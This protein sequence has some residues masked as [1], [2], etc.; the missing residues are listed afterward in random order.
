MQKRD[1][2]A[3]VVYIGVAVAVSA[4]VAYFITSPKPKPMFTIY[5][6]GDI[7]LGTNTTITVS[8]TN[9]LFITFVD[10]SDAGV[11]GIVPEGDTEV[12]WVHEGEEFLRLSVM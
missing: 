2:F 8:D 4:L 11:L 9:V 7:L 10:D 3:V 1:V 6:S 5:E 12:I